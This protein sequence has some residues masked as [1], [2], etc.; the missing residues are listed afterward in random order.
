MLWFDLH[1]SVAGYK[2]GS[3]STC[4]PRSENMCCSDKVI[5]GHGKTGYR[6]CGNSYYHCHCPGC[7]SYDR[8]DH[9]ENN[10]FCWI[11]LLFLLGNKCGTN[12]GKCIF[13]FIYKGYPYNGCTDAGNKAGNTDKWC[14]TKIDTSGKMTDYGWCKYDCPGNCEVPSYVS[15][16]MYIVHHQWIQFT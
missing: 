4:N 1:V 3:P 5:N 13:P 14:A 12:K 9:T 7:V 10:N 8:G 16:S 15:K 11:I 2:D 6:H